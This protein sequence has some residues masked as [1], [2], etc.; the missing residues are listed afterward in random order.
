MSTIRLLAAIFCFLFVGA[1]AGC[2]NPCAKALERAQACHEELCAEGGEG[3]P[4]CGD[5]FA[6]IAECSDTAKAAAE[7]SIEAEDCNRAMNLYSTASA[8]SGAE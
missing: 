4:L 2:G 8:L 7:R 3:H 5:E 6:E 1:L